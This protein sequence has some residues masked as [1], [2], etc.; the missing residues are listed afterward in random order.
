MFEKCQS[1]PEQLLIL[2]DFEGFGSPPELGDLGGKRT[3]NSDKFILQLSNA[4]FLTRYVL[5]QALPT[6]E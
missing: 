6:R 4:K 1:L 2:G 5:R 3:V